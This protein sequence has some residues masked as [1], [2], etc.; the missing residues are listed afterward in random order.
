MNMKEVFEKAKKIDKE[1]NYI[2]QVS[3]NKFVIFGKDDSKYIVCAEDGK[4]EVV[5]QVRAI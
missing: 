3:E 2:K 5:G 4:I 1:V